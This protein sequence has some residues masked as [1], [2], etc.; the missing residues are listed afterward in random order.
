VISGFPAAFS[1]GFCLCLGFQNGVESSAKWSID[2]ER[3]ATAL[4]FLF[5]SI[6][7]LNYFRDVQL[8]L[9]CGSAHRIHPPNVQ[10]ITYKVRWYNAVLMA[11][12][13]SDCPPLLPAGEHDVGIEQIK[14]LCVKR[15]PLSQTRK[16]IMKGLN[17]IINDLRR[18]VIPCHLIIDGSFLTEEINPDDVDLALVVEPE[19]YETCSREQRA[20]LVYS[21]IEI[22]PYY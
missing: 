9:L 7:V 8:V 21:F 20:F 16:E 22:Y 1:G 17:T 18:L 13:V 2:F 5:C 3:P 19:F 10:Y 14:D 12:R 6:K 11:S 15:F 4:V